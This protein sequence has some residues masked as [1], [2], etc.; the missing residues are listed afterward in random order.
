MHSRVLIIE[1]AHPGVHRAGARVLGRSSYQSDHKLC[2]DSPRLE[3]SIY[4][5]VRE[6]PVA[7][8]QYW[9][10]MLAGVH[11]TAADTTH[12]QRVALP[13]CSG[14]LRPLDGDDL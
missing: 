13:A 4:S 7:G 6:H 11:D 10:I 2:S 12:P 14:A 5:D 1:H 8:D 3:L 9:S